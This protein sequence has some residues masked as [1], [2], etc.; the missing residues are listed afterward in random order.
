MGEESSGVDAWTGET[1]QF[2]RVR[3]IASAAKQPRS[4]SEVADAAQVP[5]DETRRHVE[6]LVEDGVLLRRYNDDAGEVLYEPNEFYTEQ[7]TVQDLVAE[8]SHED[9]VEMQREFEA[10]IE[11]WCDEYGVDRPDELRSQAEATTKVAEKTELIRVA[12]DWK[13]CVY[14]LSLIRDAIKRTDPGE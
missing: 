10:K 7:E 4:V 3:V 5:E 6:Q 11:A 1:T 14:R 13:L 12:A 2:E 9:L 8:N